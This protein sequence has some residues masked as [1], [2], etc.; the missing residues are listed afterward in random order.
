[1]DKNTILTSIGNHIKFLRIKNKLS[2]EKLAYISGISY[3]LLHKIEK[4]KINTS[5]YTI[6]KILSNLNCKTEDINN[7]FETVITKSEFIN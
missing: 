4:G 5:I 3:T 6:F 1:M 7:L 2:I